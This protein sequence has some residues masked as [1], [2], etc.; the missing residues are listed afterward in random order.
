MI[1]GGV[2]EGR[3]RRLAVGDDVVRM[4]W[5]TTLDPSLLIARTDRGDQLDLLVVPPSAPAAAAER[6]MATAAAPENLLR[7]AA[8]LA[9]ES[10]AG[11]APAERS[12][13]VWDNEGGSPAL[14][15]NA[16]AVPGR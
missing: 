1:N 12:T 8:I 16:V 2:W 5:F 3:F 4:G 9:A 11:P 7:S 15:G 6:A 14:N 13:D 10:G